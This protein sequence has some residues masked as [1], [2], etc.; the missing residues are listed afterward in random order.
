MSY[1]Y[2]YSARAR[3]DGRT[4]GMDACACTL[5][6]RDNTTACQAGRQAGGRMVI[7]EH[8]GG[9]QRWWRTFIHPNKFGCRG[10]FRGIS[11]LEQEM[12]GEGGPTGGPLGH[13]IISIA[14]RERGSSRRDI[15]SVGIVSLYAVGLHVIYLGRKR[16][17]MQRSF[18][19]SR[20]SEPN[21]RRRERPVTRMYARKGCPGS[22]AKVGLMRVRMHMHASP[23]NASSQHGECSRVQRNYVCCQ[24]AGGQD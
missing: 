1:A 19:T 3:W 15:C 18:R 16:P 23:A 6:G 14:W 13:L 11:V 22:G 4:A 21:V 5:G 7:D 9:A 10:E 2:A 8:R 20:G 17:A 12:A 24:R